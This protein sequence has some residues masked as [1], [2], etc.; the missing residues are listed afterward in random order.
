MP[1]AKTKTIAGEQF[2][3]NQPYEAG[4]TLTEAEAK[5]LNQTRSE[6]VGN[7]CR[8]KVQE[9]VEA[10]DVAGAQK[11]VKDYDKSYEFTLATVGAGRLDPVERE[12]R[13]LARDAIRAKLAEVG[14]KIKDVDKEKLE[15][16]IDKTAENP[17]IIKAAK[18]VV[19]DK[20]KAVDVSL[21]ELN[22]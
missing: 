9:L 4:H 22:L 17:E 7:N 20:K 1:E 2:S 15:A 12:A 18:K 3:I 14:K 5:Q 6:N 13:K 10:G 11:F 8:K 19:E 16:L 21:G